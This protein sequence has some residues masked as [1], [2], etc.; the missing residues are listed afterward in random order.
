VT[1]IR[2]DQNLFTYIN[3]FSCK[4]ADKDALVETLVLE[5]DTV[6]RDLPGFVSA[7]IHSSTDGSRVVNYAQW[8]DLAAFGE[9]MRG[10][11][12]K[13]LIQRVH[14]FATGVDIHMFEVDRVVE[15]T[16]GGAGEIGIAL[17]LAEQAWTAIEK[18]AIEELSSIFAPDVR[19]ATAAGEGTGIDFALRVFQ[20][21]HDAYPDLSHE[22]VSAVENETG[23]EVAR[24]LVFT[25]AHKGALRHPMT[26]VE[27]PP[28]GTMLTWRASEHVTAE[29]GRIVAW[30]AYF[31]RLGMLQQLEGG[32]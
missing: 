28:T 27:L 12:G 32:S 3:V 4:P 22:L 10:E 5:T 20:H 9:M 17:Q 30:R 23:T 13:D 14:Q 2:E 8:T 31:D 21:H 11:H 6:V 24:E 18:G 19:L 29:N 16:D 25:G 15:S 26:G 1:A 7:N